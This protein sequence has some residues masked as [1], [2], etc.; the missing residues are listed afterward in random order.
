MVCEGWDMRLRTPPNDVLPNTIITWKARFDG[1]CRCGK[2]IKQGQSCLYDL[3]L[4]K[5]LC[6]SCQ[7]LARQGLVEQVPLSEV[8]KVMDRVKQIWVLPKPLSMPVKEE[9]TVLMEKLRTTYAEDYSARR[10]L[11]E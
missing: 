9:L 5:L 8:E 7:R 4:R 11:V 6:R 10:L 2:K 1:K 3:K